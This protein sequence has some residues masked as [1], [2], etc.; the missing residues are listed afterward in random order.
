MKIS[1]YESSVVEVARYSTTV[2]VLAFDPVLSS[3]AAIMK[4]VDTTPDST[5]TRTGVPSLA[6]NLPKN[7]KNA[8]S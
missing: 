5:F 2:K 7:G 6:L 1:R 4:I 3:T 8:P